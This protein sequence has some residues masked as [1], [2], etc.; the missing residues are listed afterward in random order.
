MVCV[1]LCVQTACVAPTLKRALLAQNRVN[2]WRRIRG[3]QGLRESETPRLDL[4]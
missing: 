4:L 3:E 1:H 2:L